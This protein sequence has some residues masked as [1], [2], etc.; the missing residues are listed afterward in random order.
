[1]I[2]TGC[3]RITTKYFVCRNKLN[4]VKKLLF[5]NVYNRVNEILIFED[6]RAWPPG[7][8]LYV[9]R[10]F[11]ARAAGSE[12]YL[13]SAPQVM[14]FNSQMHSA[15]CRSNLRFSQPACREIEH[16]LGSNR[17]NGYA[18]SASFKNEYLINYCENC[19]IMELLWLV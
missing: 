14:M 13:A 4:W 9:H 16:I 19:K 6:Y 18:Y 15:E 5:C 11:S 10:L 1:M 7:L 2:Y 8:L 3:P 12:D 17:L